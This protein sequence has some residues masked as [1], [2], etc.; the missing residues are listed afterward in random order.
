MLCRS[1]LEEAKGYALFVA[2]MYYVGMTIGLVHEVLRI[3]L[4]WR[5]PG[6]H[7]RASE[8]TRLAVLALGD[9]VTNIESMLALISFVIMFGGVVA[10]PI[11]RRRRRVSSRSGGNDCVLHLVGRVGLPQRLEQPANER[12]PSFG[13]AER[14]RT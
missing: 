10:Y 7:Q 5:M 3:V 2:M 14:D 12:Q 8:E 13:A 4:F 11:L 9:L 6:L 1:F